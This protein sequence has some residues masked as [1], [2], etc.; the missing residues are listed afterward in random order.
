MT[1]T[2]TPLAAPSARRARRVATVR[3][4]LRRPS[5][6]IGTAVLCFWVLCALVGQAIVPDDP[7][8]TDP[9]NAL[10]SPSG[11][12][13]FG[14]DALGRDVFSRVVV[15]SRA[16]L[17]ISLL[18]AGLATLLGTTIG[19]VMGYFGGLVD[20]ALSRVAEAVMALPSVILALLALTALG[21]SNLTLVVVVG[22]AYSWVI[23]RTVRAAVLTERGAEYVAAARVRGER[24]PYI[25]FGEILPNVVPVVI[26]EFTVRVGMAV[27]SVASLSFLGFGVQ[28]P[29]PDWGLQIADSYGVLSAGA[30]WTA[31]FPALAIASLVVSVFLIADNVQGALSE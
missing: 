1:A 15:G 25:M 26:V 7:Y 27:F 11:A 12:H 17:T 14:T 8:A 18:A 31:L 13:W 19:L 3:A 16:I 4:L 29:S 5:F 10:A 20:E 2:S 28:P 30:W 23:A 6:V 9:A 24:S 21:P 22:F